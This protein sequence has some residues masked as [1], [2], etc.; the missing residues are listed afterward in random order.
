[1]KNYSDSPVFATLTVEGPISDVRAILNRIQYDNA[2]GIDFNQIDR[3]PAQ[4][5]VDDSMEAERVEKLYNYF[6]AVTSNITYEDELAYMELLNSDDKHLFLLGKEYVLN[7]RQYGYPDYHEWC[8][9]H[10]GT[11]RNTVAYAR[12]DDNTIAFATHRTPA[13]TAIRKLSAWMPNMPFTYRW[14]D[15]TLNLPDGKVVRQCVVFQDGLEMS[16]YSLVRARKFANY[17]RMEGIKEMTGMTETDNQDY[18]Y[19]PDDYD[20]YYNGENLPF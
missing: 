11:D 16:A 7:R 15:D 17:F 18:A 14:E 10:W 4:L 2:A 13:C 6:C 5:D 19:I 12:V 9:E 3:V 1:M 8:R 20:D